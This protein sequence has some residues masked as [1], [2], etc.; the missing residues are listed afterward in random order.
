MYEIQAE[1]NF[2]EEHRENKENKEN[3]FLE[4]HRENI[5]NKA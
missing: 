3:N 2:L 1:I 5:E 4:E